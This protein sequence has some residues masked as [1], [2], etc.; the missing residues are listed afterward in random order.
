MTVVGNA[1]E[2]G[3]EMIALETVLDTECETVFEL[4][5]TASELAVAVADEEE[6]SRD[7]EEKPSGDDDVVAMEFD[8]T[9]GELE[10]GALKTD[11]EGLR[12]LV[13]DVLKTKGGELEEL[14]ADDETD[15]MLVLWL[16]KIEE[17]TD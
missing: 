2:L 17:E 3:V 11:E 16:A 12:E 4:K 5:T 6:D 15:F 7:D 13:I 9:D 8:D 14:A 10:A 1:K